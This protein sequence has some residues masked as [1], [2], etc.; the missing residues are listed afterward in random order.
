MHRAHTV[1]LGIIVALITL[2]QPAEVLVA[3]T[4]VYDSLL[5]NPRISA[6]LLWYQDGST[7]AAS[8]DNWSEAKKAHL[9]DLLADMAAGN[10]FPLSEPPELT[11]NLRLSREDAWTLYALRVAH[12]LWVE[13]EKMV[14]WSVLDFDDDALALLYDGTHMYSCGTSE[15]GSDYD[16]FGMVTD[17]NPR[18]SFDFLADSGMVRANQ[19]ETV[20][21]F[22]YWGRRNLIHILGADHN[23]DGHERL[24]GYRGDP[25]VDKVLVPL[26]DRRHI[27]AGCWGTSGLF[28]AVLRS[29][30]I[31]VRT[32]TT[33]FGT[34]NNDW[35][36]RHS[37]FEL[38]TLDLGLTHGDDIYNDW[39]RPSKTNRVHTALLFHSLEWLQDFVDDPQVLD[40]NQDWC[41]PPEDQAL[42]NSERHIREV[43]IAYFSDA[44]LRRRTDEG[45]ETEVTEQFR[46]SLIGVGVDN[47]VFPYAHPYFADSEI[48]DIVRR[49]D[50]EIRRI[51]NGIWDD[52]REQVLFSPSQTAP[53]EPDMTSYLPFASFAAA[54]GQPDA[55][56]PIQFKHYPIGE[57]ASYAWDF[58]DG[59]T[60]SEA[61]PSHTFTFVD[62]ISVTLT[63][64]GPSGTTT[65]RRTVFVGPVDGV[66]APAD[67][68]V[69]GP[70]DAATGLSLPVELSWEALPAARRY[71]VQIA[72]DEA[73]S[74]LAAEARRLRD[75]RVAMD[76]LSPGV[77]YYWRVRAR[78]EGGVG[79]WSAARSFETGSAPATVTLQSPEDAAEGRPAYVSL[80]WN[81]DP[82]ADRYHLQIAKD[83]GFST[84][85][86]EDSTLADTSFAPGPLAYSTTFYWRVRAAN[87][88]GSGPWSETRSFTTA[89][90]TA[91]EGAASLPTEFALHPPYP[92]PFNPSTTIGFDVPQAGNI[93]LTI[94]DAL[95]RLV[96]SLV[97]D[98]VGAGTGQWSAGRYNVTWEAKDLPSGVYFVRMQAGRFSSSHQI[99]LVK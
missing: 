98:G 87:G 46:Q 91:T 94:Y 15:C 32:T 1:A 50:D 39:L 89:V 44:L 38:P 45:T 59:E 63:V 21:A 66:D 17:W 56:Q 75:V 88:F 49:I 77:R 86:V 7:D 97:P 6:G 41:N 79:S 74:E 51:G 24:Y 57:I 93:R 3:Q 53:A 31:P 83:Q 54:P 43:A 62:S 14:G 65:S 78:N 58:G 48:D 47:G 72:T 29:V 70:A 42:F 22:T 19:L 35:R 33:H 12:S 20:F 40:C 71:D 84:S 23:P 60:S 55:L 85:V 68:S 26:P 96:E 67:V 92:N 18:F 34:P 28:N 90:G 13:G 76:G 5:A 9:S 16:S 30:N 8:Y 95:G 52:G 4:T 36:A 10:P 80:V 11:D 69:V 82:I 27:T 2:C 61:D 64:T 81:P 25:P 37:R 73:F 99:L